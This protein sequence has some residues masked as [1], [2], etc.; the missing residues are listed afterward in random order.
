MFVA[1]QLFACCGKLSPSLPVEKPPFGSF[2]SIFCV[3]SFEAGIFLWSLLFSTIYPQCIP[4]FEVVS[5]RWSSFV[6]PG[7]V[8]HTIVTS[9]SFE[10]AAIS[11]ETSSL[12]VVTH[13]CPS[14][15]VP[16]PERT[17]AN[18]PLLAALFEL[19]AFLSEVVALHPVG[20]TPSS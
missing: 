14:A 19:A 16:F 13:H 3:K 17:E 5:Q 11:H 9:A 7:V 4:D 1:F 2:A 18:V 10:P 8:L 6:T 12:V 15:V 20:R